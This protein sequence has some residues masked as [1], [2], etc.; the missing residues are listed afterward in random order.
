MEDAKDPANEM[1]EQF[2]SFRLNFV[3][4]RDFFTHADA[5]AIQAFNTMI[6]QIPPER[7]A[8]F[9]IGK[10]DSVSKAILNV[11][12]KVKEVGDKIMTHNEA[13][14]DGT[15][16]EIQFGF[17]NQLQQFSMTAKEIS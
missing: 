13:L 14:H 11:E 2:T 9:G 16:K 15:R 10:V 8:L 1:T 7:K 6:D 5:S 17:S 3:A 4:V 12:Q